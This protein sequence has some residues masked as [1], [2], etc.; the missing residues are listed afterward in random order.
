MSIDTEALYA[1]QQVKTKYI[2]Y[3]YYIRNFSISKI[4]ALTNAELLECATDSGLPTYT[5][6]NL[7]DAAAAE[8]AFAYSAGRIYS[9]SHII[10]IIE[11]AQQRIDKK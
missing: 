3:L 4:R 10:E 9:E 11:R 8:H 7:D 2:L 6:E 1:G 5:L